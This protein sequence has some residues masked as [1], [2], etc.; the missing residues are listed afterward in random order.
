MH[1]YGTLA[2]YLYTNVQLKVCL[3]HSRR[4]CHMV[5]T[6]CANVNVC[7]LSPSLSPSR[8]GGGGGGGGDR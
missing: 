8:G 2:T 3:N 6:A 7:V 5:H 4:T 1:H